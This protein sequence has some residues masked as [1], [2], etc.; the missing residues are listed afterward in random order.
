MRGMNLR[1]IFYGWVPDAKRFGSEINS[2]L[3]RHNA[4]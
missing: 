4:D 2:Y 1:F 3:Q